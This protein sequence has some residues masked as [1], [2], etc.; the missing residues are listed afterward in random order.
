MSPNEIREG[1]ECICKNGFSVLRVDIRSI[2]K[3][4]KTFKNFYSKLNCT[5]KRDLFFRNWATDNSIC[6]DSN[7]QIENYTVLHQVRESDR[8][9]GLNIFMHKEVYFKPRADLSINSNDVESLCIKIH[10]KKDINIL[11]SVMYRPPNGDMT[12]FDKFRKKLFSANVQTS[13]NII[14]AGDLNIKV[15]GY[16]ST[17]K[18]QHFLSSMFQYKIILTI[19]KSTRV[20]R[21]TATAIDHIIIDTV[22]TGIQ[23]RS[24]II[25]TDISDHFP[26]VFVLNTCEK[27][28]PEDKAQFIYKRLYREE[29]IELFKHE[30]SQVE[31]NNIIKIQDNPSTAYGSFFNI[32]FKTYDK[33]F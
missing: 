9:G 22:I 13:E 14:F 17:T 23:H 24:G 3:N 28:K 30:L 18:V 10:H 20:T 29:Q 25:K 12:V 6:N 8:G 4:F 26:I 21:N 11:F 33:Y 32:F 27:S 16:E 31:W 2:N 19:D 15:I 1:F 5:F 7:F